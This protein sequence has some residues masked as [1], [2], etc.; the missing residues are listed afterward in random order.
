MR[1]ASTTEKEVK[2]SVRDRFSR[3]KSRCPPGKTVFART[4]APASPPQA[5]MFA[6]ASHQI[7]PASPPLAST[8]RAPHL[9]YGTG[10]RKL[11][12]PTPI[13]EYKLLIYGKP[14]HSKDKGKDEGNGECKSKDWSG[15]LLGISFIQKMHVFHLEQISSE[16]ARNKHRDHDHCN[17]FAV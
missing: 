8:R 2:M 15:R 6:S 4:S 3:C 9:I 12:K 11:Q 13:N 14:R 10:I 1:N 5:S 17:R 16:R 7:V